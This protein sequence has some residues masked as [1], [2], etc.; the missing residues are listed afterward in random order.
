MRYV[1]RKLVELPPALGGDDFRKMR[2]AYLRY[3][4]LP[5]RERVQRK[6]PDRRLPYSAGLNNAVIDLFSGRCAFCESP[7]KLELYRFRP[8]AEALPI[9][10]GDF[11]FM[12]YG[13][14]ADAWQNLYSICPGC[15]PKSA[16]HFPVDGSRS[17][18][19]TAKQYAAYAKANT[20]DWSLDIAE[21]NLLLDPCVDNRISQHVQLAA[22]GMLN[23]RTKRGHATIAQF[24]LNRDGLV[25]RRGNALRQNEDR[26]PELLS[27]PETYFKSPE[28]LSST[29]F[30]GLVGDYIRARARAG[31]AGSGTLPAV[32]PAR[33]RAS[34]PKKPKPA[35]VWR[36]QGVETRNFKS[37]ENLAFD[38]PGQPEG[39]DDTRPPALLILGENASG[40]S[41]ILEAITLALVSDDARTG[42]DIDPTK[43]LLDP[44]YLGGEGKRRKTRG[45]VTLR[46][47][48]QD[49]RKRTID[50]A[51]TASGYRITGKTPENLPVFAYGA[52][53]HYLDDFLDWAPHRGVVSLFKSDSLLSNPEKWLLEISETKFNMVVRS[54]RDIFGVGEDF[55]VIERDLKKKRCMVVVK[56]AGG[57]ESRTPLSSVSSG[58]RTILALA[59]DVMR[60]LLDSQR[61]WPFKTLNDAHGIIMIDEIEA[62]LHPRWK[63]GIMKGI[64]NALPNMTFIVTTHDPLCVRGM[65]DNEVMVLQRLPGIVKGSSQLPIVVETLTELPRASQLTVEQLLTSDLFNLFDTDEAE[66]GQHMAELVDSLLASKSE[67]ID[68]Q[69]ASGKLLAKFRE[70]I[71]TALPI[72]NTEVSRLVHEAVGDYLLQRANTSPDARM[73][74][75]QKTKQR[76]IKALE[77][78]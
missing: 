51:L 66:S 14:L 77:Q 40:K 9:E 20:G 78:S 11:G 18:Q 73:K 16:Y 26:M 55:S 60:W 45:K 59:C 17:K 63:V 21:T 29:E 13:W 15:R 41:S 48:D 61:N 1:D 36:L 3:L 70:Q 53:R 54:L 62:H 38:M 24:S 28:W 23:G 68:E 10:D 76:I 4:E 43:L 71:E 39:S 44:T 65:K 42:L 52:Y 46:F 64:R 22:N 25:N 69:S 19:P 58:F 47:V 7:S 32:K 35:P 67:A 5:D 8:T 72:G 30:P 33:R 74:L 50:M 34:P 12:A 6:Q 49:G 31:P 75:R 37:L 56:L 27:R 57:R 2:E